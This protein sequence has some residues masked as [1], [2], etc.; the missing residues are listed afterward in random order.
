MRLS[1]SHK[2]CPKGRDLPDPVVMDEDLCEWFEGHVEEMNAP[3]QAIATFKLKFVT[4][5]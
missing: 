3:Y 5:C 4:Y 2:C 1:A